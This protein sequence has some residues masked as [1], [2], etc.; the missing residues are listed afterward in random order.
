MVT[1]KQNLQEIQNRKSKPA[2]TENHQFM[3]INSK[4][5]RKEQQGNTRGQKITNKKALVSPYL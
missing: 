1:T 5:E 2:I 3:K 4:T